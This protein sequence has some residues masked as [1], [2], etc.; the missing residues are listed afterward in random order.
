MKKQNKKWILTAAALVMLAATAGAT[1]LTNTTAKAESSDFVMDGAAIRYNEPTGIRFAAV[2]TEDLKNQVES[3]ENQSFG[4]LILPN[5]YLESITIDEEHPHTTQLNGIQYNSAEGLKAVWN[6]EEEQYE[7]RYS[8]A[9]VQYGNYNRDWFGIVYIKTVDGDS[10]TYDYADV[11]NGNNVRAVSQVA[12]GVYDLTVA[13]K[14]ALLDDYIYQAEYLEAHPVSDWTA[15]G[16]AESEKAKALAYATAQKETVSAFDSAVEVKD[17]STAT[18]KY[19]ALG[20]FAKARKTLALNQLKATLVSDKISA[21]PATNALSANDWYAINI[22]KTAYNALDADVQALVTN[23]ATLTAVEEAYNSVYE[24]KVLFD[25]KTLS[26]AV[27]AIGAP[28][29]LP[30]G[31]DSTVNNSTEYVE[32]TTISDETV[33]SALGMRLLGSGNGWEVLQ[34]DFDASTIEGYDIY[35]KSKLACP[36]NATRNIRWTT[37]N[38]G[39]GAN[40]GVSAIELTSLDSTA[41]NWSDYTISASDFATQ[42]ARFANATGLL[43]AWNTHTAEDHIAYV[44]PVIAIKNL[45]QDMIDKIDALN[46]S[47]DMGNLTANDYYSIYPVITEYNA[48]SDVQKNAVTN[49]ATLTAIEEA[50]NAKY[51]VKVLFDGKTLSD[52]VKAIGAPNTL[53]EGADSTVNNST[54][55]VETTTISDETV[56]SAL[57]MRLLGSGNGWEVLQMDFDASTIEGYDIYFKSKLAC[58]F[59]ATRNIR[60][61][62]TNLGKGANYGVSAIELTSLDSTATNWSDYT[63]SASDFET[64]TTSTGDSATGLVIAWNTHSAANHIAYVGPIFAIK[65]K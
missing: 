42:T 59:N 31:A 29:T 55:Y 27:K 12:E 40:Y 62:T 3:S 28:N 14:Q 50:Y 26:D 63:I 51:E 25:G 1:A 15:E 22:V 36:F 61:T 9:D 24:V 46:E 13:D 49:S 45:V 58:P 47:L 4:A 10:V 54:E 32:T 20:T 33:G 8:I 39:K 30:E 41:T 65:A 38:L 6:T 17:L 7:V 35:F 11:V 5:D 64:K 57:G 23:S 2:V 21:L 48:L 56:G 34:M 53:P 18:T 44:S 19:E 43:I 16:V 37:T 60:W 52:A